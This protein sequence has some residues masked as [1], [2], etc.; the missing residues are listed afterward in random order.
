MSGRTHVFEGK[1][2]AGGTPS[3]RAMEY[4]SITL[5]FAGAAWLAL[6]IVR[7]LAS[8][9][10]WVIPI[11]VMAGFVAQDFVSGLVH[12]ACDT[13]GSPETPLVGKPFIRTFREHHIDPKSI[14]R[15]DFVETNGDNCLAT[16][17]VLLLALWL[18]PLSP[19]AT[20][21]LSAA[22][23]VLSL[24]C[25][26]FM[27]NQAHKWAHMDTPPNAVSWFQRHGLILSPEHHAT[28]HSAPFDRNYCIT[29]GWMNE[30]LEKIGFF[31]RLESLITALTGA[32]PRR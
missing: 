17:P 24:T 16:L 11:A 1:G 15:H 7:T 4:F 8:G 3:R 19:G 25:F 6:R 13:W 28:H 5:F 26:G 14:T 30:P 32:L 2:Y 23:F 21:S 27:T 29:A 10:L 12:W 20:W 22:V 9:D 31:V 18:L